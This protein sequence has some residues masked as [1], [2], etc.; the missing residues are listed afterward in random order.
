MNFRE[1]L[2]NVNNV[3]LADKSFILAVAFA[4]IWIRGFA[5]PQDPCFP[6]DFWDSTV[7]G[8]VVQVLRSGGYY[9]FARYQLLELT[10]ELKLELSIGL[11]SVTV[12]LIARLACLGFRL[13]AKSLREN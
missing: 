13:D 10:P 1:I 12:E 9:A 5:A 11:T 7:I 4:I 6:A 8:K 2:N 3:K